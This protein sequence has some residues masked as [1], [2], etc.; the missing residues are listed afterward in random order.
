MKQSEGRRQGRQEKEREDSN[1]KRDSAFDCA[2]KALNQLGEK[3]C[4]VKHS[5]VQ[6]EKERS[7][8]EGDWV[9]EGKCV[10]VSVSVC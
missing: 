5:E 8:E 10:C 9:L 7:E 2:N 1:K 6:Q 3:C 4:L